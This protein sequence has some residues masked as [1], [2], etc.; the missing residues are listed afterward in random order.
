MRKVGPFERIAEPASR[1]LWQ[2]IRDC[3]PFA[4]GSERPVW[5]VSMAPYEA[6]RMVLALRMEAGADA[7]YDW[8]GGLVWLR[9]DGEPEADAVRRLV[10]SHGGG[11][12][13]LVRA[14]PADRAAIPVFEPQAGALAALSARLKEQFDPQ[15]ILNPGRMV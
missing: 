14:S 7:F 13:T 3:V 12:A 10:R 11:H 1:L 4:D 15:G 5:R 6:H 9:I 8:Q 2:D